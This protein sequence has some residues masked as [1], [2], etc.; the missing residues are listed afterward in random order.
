MSNTNPTKN[1]WWTQVLRKVSSSC[2]TSCTCCVT[3][4]TNL[5]TCHEWVKDQIV[6]TTY[7][8]YPYILVI[9]IRLGC[10]TPL[11]TISQLYH[12]GQFYWWR[13]LEYLEKTTDLSHVT[14]NLHHIILYLL[15]FAGVG[16]EFAMLVAIGTDSIGSCK[17]RRQTHKK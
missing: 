11:S 17:C 1:Q 6:I 15:H 2:S 12:V 9:C 10:L 14:G 16:L 8:T 7:R 5:V 4:V 13:K 3:L